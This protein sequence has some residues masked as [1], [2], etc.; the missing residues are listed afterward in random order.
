MFSLQSQQLH[1]T[2]LLINSD[3]VQHKN[4][5]HVDIHTNAQSHTN[6]QI[7]NHQKFGM[8]ISNIHYVLVCHIF[9]VNICISSHIHWYTLNWIM[10]HVYYSLTEYNNVGKVQLPNLHDL[11]HLKR[12]TKNKVYA[13]FIPMKFEYTQ[14]A[15]QLL[16]TAIQFP[17]TECALQQHN[18]VS[19]QFLSKQLPLSGTDMQLTMYVGSKALHLHTYTHLTHQAVSARSFKVQSGFIACDLMVILLAAIASFPFP[20]CPL[21]K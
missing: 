3:R 13:S 7:W 5:S 11:Y 15:L 1:L 10:Q 12:S 17:L 14:F 19:V 4:R 16:Q 21:V 6:C 18:R 2:Q 20:W 8:P 9:I